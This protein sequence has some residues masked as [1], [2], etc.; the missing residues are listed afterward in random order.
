[1]FIGFL[2]FVEALME[3][4]KLRDH[5]FYLFLEFFFVFGT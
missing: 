5:L 2:H 1:M 3:L 4:L